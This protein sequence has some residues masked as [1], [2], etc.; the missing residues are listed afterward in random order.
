MAERSRERY[1]GL[2]YEDPDFIRFFEQV[3]PMAELARAEHRL[4]PAVAAQGRRDRG[5]ARDPV[6]VRVDPEPAAAAVLVR[7]GRRAGGGGRWSSSARC[8]RDWPFFRGLV[9]TLEMALF[10]TDLGVAAS[11]TCGSSS[12][13]L[14]RALLAAICG[15]SYDSVVGAAA[16]DH[17]RSRGCSTRRRRCSAGSRTATRGSIRSR[18]SRSSCS[19]ALRAGREEAREPLLATITGIAAGMRNTG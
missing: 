15:T 4:A 19:R 9:G 16:G 18:T 12:P 6:G 10:K 2:V 7:R 3:T 1:R 17:R 14:R 5:A 11:A 13:A 8:A